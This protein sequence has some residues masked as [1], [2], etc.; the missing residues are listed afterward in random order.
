[1]KTVLFICCLYATITGYAQPGQSKVGEHL[2]AASNIAVD[3]V[4]LNDHVGGN[5]SVVNF[6][7]PVTLP[8]HILQLEGRRINP[9][10][11]KLSFVSSD[12]PFNAGFDLQRSDG[13]G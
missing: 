10:Q 5:C 11:V 9:S 3:S 2:I 12:E 7:S 4:A 1:M 13:D 6:C 8:V